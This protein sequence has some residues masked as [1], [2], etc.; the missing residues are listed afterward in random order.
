MEG[1][2]D[3]SLD[4]KIDVLS[5]LFQPAHKQRNVVLWWTWKCCRSVQ[6]RNYAACTGK[7]ELASW[8]G[9]VL[10][11]FLGDVQDH[12]NSNV[13]ARSNPVRTVK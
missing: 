8:S 2:F 11:E 12:L 9:E 5:A 6:S 10:A 3:S 1:E 4:I 7:D 13:H